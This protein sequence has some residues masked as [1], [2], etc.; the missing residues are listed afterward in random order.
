MHSVHVNIS[1]INASRQ[2]VELH[3]GVLVS[4]I[5]VEPKGQLYRLVCR[6]A[7]ERVRQQLK[8]EHS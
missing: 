6:H 3:H 2:A 7:R 1:S 4:A 8:R 5:A